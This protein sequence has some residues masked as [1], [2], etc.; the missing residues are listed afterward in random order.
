[1]TLPPG[2]GDETAAGIAVVGADGSGERQVTSEGLWPAWSPDGKRI[3]FVTEQGLKLIDAVEGYDKFIDKYSKKMWLIDDNRIIDTFTWSP[4]GVAIKEGPR[5]AWD[6]ALSAYP[7]AP[8]GYNQY[9]DIATSGATVLLSTKIE[10]YDILHRT[11]WIK[12]EKLVFD[13]IVSTISP[14]QLFDNCYDALPYI[15]RDFHKIVLPV[16]HV[17]PEHVYFL[18]YANDDD[19]E[20]KLGLDSR[21]HFTAPAD[22]AYLVRVTDTRG[23]SGERFVY[24]L[25]EVQA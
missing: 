25:V 20:R 23:F 7:H 15:G 8:D 24:R 11:V 18:Y 10:R 22:G 6:T 19:G 3:V 21:L 2:G 14:D 9:F 4:K 16:E 17:F 13:L 1:M 5:A 12:G